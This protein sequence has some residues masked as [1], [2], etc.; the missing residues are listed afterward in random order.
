MKSVNAGGG[1]TPHFFMRNFTFFS[2]NFNV[3]LMI[4]WPIL[5]YSSM[6]LGVANSAKTEIDSRKSLESPVHHF[7]KQANGVPNGNTGEGPP[8]E[9]GEFDFFWES[10]NYDFFIYC[11]ALIYSSMFLRFSNVY[12]NRICLKEIIFELCR[13]KSK[14]F[15]VCCTW[16][17]TAFKIYELKMSQDH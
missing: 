2:R 12:E 13:N 15:K 5:I 10:Y 8:T 3:S 6:F 11:P 7:Y 1:G 16:D 17:E 9:N 14:Y 4:F